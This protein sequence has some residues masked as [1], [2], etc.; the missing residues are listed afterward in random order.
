MKKRTGGGTFDRTE[1]PV[2]FVASGTKALKAASAVN[3]HLLIAVNEL[4]SANARDDLD[5]LLDSGAYVFLDSGIF[6]L[7]NKHA[8]AH[9]VPMDIALGLA[10]DEIQGFNELWDRYCDIATRYS[11][12]LWGFIELDQGGADNKRRTRARL[13]KETGLAPMPVYHP[14]NDG[15]DYFDELCSEYDRICFG[16]VVQAKQFTRKRLLQTLYQRQRYDHPDVW[17][18]VLGFTPNEWVHGMPWYGSCDSSSWLRN[19]RWSDSHKSH[20]ACKGV[21]T[22]VGGMR[23]KYDV[24]FEAPNGIER[25]WQFAAL[26]G[27]TFL[28]DAWRAYTNDKERSLR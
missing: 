20:A 28:R 22:F 11:D 21:G 8:R 9:D 23:Y 27:G 5:R 1:Q 19:V 4:E 10:P 26:Q 18:H 24:D 6:N 17:V 16:N 14:I 12:R 7:T 13:E 3:R 25:A 2:Y 15:W